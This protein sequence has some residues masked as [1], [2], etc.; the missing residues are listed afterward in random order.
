[1]IKKR[2]LIYISLI[3]LVVVVVLGT[4]CTSAKT[5]STEKNLFTVVIDA[6][7]G[8]ID[9]GVVGKTTGVKESELKLLF[10]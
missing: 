4:N 1:M 10:A 8:G 2:L 9:N 5:N 7:H 3:L 6:G